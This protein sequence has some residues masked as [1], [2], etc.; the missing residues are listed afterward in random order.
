[1]RATYRH[2]PS[3]LRLRW[4]LYAVSTPLIVVLLAVAAKM[5]SVVLVGNS[6]IADFDRHDIEALR[7]D[8][9]MLEFVNVIDPAKTSFANADL[10]VLEGRLDDAEAKF[11]ESLTRTDH[12]ASCPAR[13]NLEL[14]QETL[15]DI[16][17]RSGRKDDAE[18]WY[19]SAIGVVNDAPPACFADNDDPNEDRRAIRHEALPR[20]EQKL[21]NLRRPPEPPPP[22]PNPIDPPPPP[23]SLTQMTS[24]PP[25]PHLGPAPDG[26]GAGDGAERAPQ[27]GEGADQAPQPREGSDQAPQPGEGADEAPRPG[28][29]SAEAPRPGDG[30]VPQPRAQ[31]PLPGPNMPAPPT[32]RGGEGPVVGPEGGDIDVLNP[33]SPDRLPSV[34]GGGPPGQELGIGDGDPLEQLRKLLDNANAHGDN[35]E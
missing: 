31:P 21:A 3:R 7:G 33:V 20:L 17:T 8:V 34:G 28:D 13:V 24:A 6:A 32:A 2:G 29:G 9:A 5:I 14:V 16:A 10:L 12:S 19:R 27:P 23:T 11:R 22:P 1:M 35:R 25:L 15:G 26:A 18:R 4:R 30:E